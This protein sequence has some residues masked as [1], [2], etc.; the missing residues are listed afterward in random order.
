ML[1]LLYYDFLA[2]FK[3]LWY[4]VLIITGLAF[5]VRILWSETFLAIF[6]N[7]NFFIGLVIQYVALGFLC[8]FGVLIIVLSIIIQAQWFDENILS[9]QGQLTNMYPISSVQL[10]MSKV[11]NSFIWACILSLVSIGVFSVFCVGTDVFK[12]IIEAIAD[13]S[14][15]NNIK[16]SFGKIMSTSC[17]FTSTT[18]VSL[19]SLCYLAQTLGQV[20]SNFKN[21]M[22]FISFWAIFVIVILLLYLI[23]SAFGVVHLFNEA[24]ANKQSETVLRLIMSMGTKFSFINIL[25][26]LFY[27]FMAGCILR[28]RLNIM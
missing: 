1:N 16:I 20:F 8:A 3:K 17:F 18:T 15:N 23:F 25:L 21:L 9:T 19:I 4:Y 11:I 26:S 28:A 12:G 2:V 10:V 24:I 13:L 7:S 22:V 5:I 6:D 27:G 14:T